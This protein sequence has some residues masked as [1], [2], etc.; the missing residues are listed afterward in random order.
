MNT[1]TADSTKPMELVKDKSIPCLLCEERFP[2]TES[3][4]KNPLL[5]HLLSVHKIVI[6]DVDKISYFPK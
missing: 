3:G 1:I 5:A 2:K 6:G 4:I